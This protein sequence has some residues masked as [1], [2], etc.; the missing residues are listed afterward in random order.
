MFKICIDEQAAMARSPAE[1]AAGVAAHTPYIDQLRR[2]ARYVASERLAPAASAR[3]LRGA[4][5]KVVATQGP[6]AE[7]REQ[8]GGFYIVDAEHLDEAIELA[9]HNPALG[10]VGV[11]IEIRPVVG[12]VP[13]SAA[14]AT[15]YL[16]AAH[17]D[18]AAG[19][20]DAWCAAVREWG[21][22]ALAPSSSATTVRLR[23]GKPVLA[24]GPF[25]PGHEQLGGYR[26]VEAH[27]LDAA[28]GLAGTLTGA[29]R[30]IEVRAIRS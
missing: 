24:D 23:D 6:Y 13:A 14:G 9:A 22:I 15:S 2:N 20:D 1:A 8:F 4:T 28:A 10:T 17:R 25:A 11:A 5:G 7:S 26:V 19:D 21:G 12:R 3:V 29:I 30:T 18:E 16:L 27:D